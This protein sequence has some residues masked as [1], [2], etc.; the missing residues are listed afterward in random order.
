MI[1]AVQSIPASE[2][3]LEKYSLAHKEDK[4]CTLLLKFCKT[5]WPPKQSLDKELKPYWDARHKMSVEGKLDLLLYGSRIIVP[6][7]M[8]A[9]TLDKL[10]EGHQGILRCRLRAQESVWWPGISSQ[11]KDKIQRCPTCAEL[12][13]NPVEP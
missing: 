10:H 5:E 12:A 9:S 3:R 8:Q 7:S 11:I 1:T 2:Q 6:L 4:V 13:I